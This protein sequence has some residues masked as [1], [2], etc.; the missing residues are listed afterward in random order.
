MMAILGAFL[1]VD[2]PAEFVMRIMQS[3]D[4]NYVC[5][6][7]NENMCVVVNG[8]TIVSRPYGKRRRVAGI[9][10]VDLFQDI[11]HD[12]ISGAK[13]K[14]YSLWE[15]EINELRKLGA[16]AEMCFGEVTF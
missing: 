7:T 13:A 11:S 15:K 4:G 5:K 8:G 9:S 10:H 12:H 1:R 14:L 16:K 6:P 2:K 3:F